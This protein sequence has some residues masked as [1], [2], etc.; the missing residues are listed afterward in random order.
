M[1]LTAEAA[2]TPKTAGNTPTRP[3][4]SPRWIWPLDDAAPFSTQRVQAIRHRLHEHPLMQ[5]P[6]LAELA[7]AL[8]PTKQCRFIGQGAQADSAFQHGDAD[9]LGRTIEEVFARIE[10]PGSW[11]A[12]YNVETHAA[13]RALLEEV[14]DSARPL[15]EAQEGRIFQV[16]GFIFVSAPPSVTPFHIDRENNFWLQIRGR[17]VMN[18]WDARDEGVVP[19]RVREDFVV[20]GGLDGVRFE[21]GFVARSH[22]FDVGPG[23]GVY[24]PSTS[25][26]MT[27]SDTGWVR[28]GDGVAVSI[29]VVFYTEATR[30]AANVH[31]WNQLLRRR[32]GST[33]LRPGESAWLDRLKYPFGRTFIELRR[34]LRG[35]KVQ[36]GF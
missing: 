13:Y 4:G 22:E 15:V 31:A 9:T 19:A 1:T 27:R 28:P 24:F 8:Y 20:Y 16:G 25:P 21:P 10:E 12:L 34:R 3:D 5:L 23:E 17:K 33:P 30:R 32:F 11:V 18:V 6:A 36:V 35:H 14:I 26:H 29:G 7:K 2:S